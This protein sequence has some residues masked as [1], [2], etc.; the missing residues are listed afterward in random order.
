VA[1]DWV[2]SFKK[3]KKNKKRR[4]LRKWGIERITEG[5]NMIKV[6]HMYIWKYY[7][8][9]S[10]FVQLIYTNEIILKITGLNLNFLSFLKMVSLISNSHLYILDIFYITYMHYKY[11]LKS[12]LLFYLLFF[13]EQIVTSMDF[14]GSK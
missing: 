8:E 12:Q 10:H 9:T 13:D 5:V 4:G 11:P 6:H 7:N 1:Y 14:N 2:L 3:H